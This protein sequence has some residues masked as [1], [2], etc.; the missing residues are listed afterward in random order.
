MEEKRFYISTPIYYP[1]AKAHIGHA[2]T[3]VLS[4]AMVRYKKM[5]GYETFFLTGMDEHGQKVARAAKEAGKTPQA[6]VDEM[7][8]MWSGLWKSLLIENDDFIRT[9]EK[10]HIDAV[11][12]IFR[13]I[14]DKGDI[15]LSEYEGWYC[16]P[17]ETFFTER[18]LAEGKLCPDCGRP[19]ELVKEEAYFFKMSKYQDQLL[20]HMEQHPDFIQPSSRRNEMINFVKSGLEDLSISRTTF[21]WGIPVP[22]NSK[23]VIYVWFDALSNYLTA[24]GWGTAEDGNY[25]KFWPCDIHLVGKDIVRFHTVIWPAMLL[26]ADIPLP[27]QIFGHGWVLLDSGKMSKSKG[28]VVDPVVLIEKY[29]PEA[30]RYFLL[31]EIPSGADGYYAEI[32]LAQRV[33]T[34]LANDFGNLVSR[35]V[36]MAEK[37]FDGKAPAPGPEEEPDRELRELASEV[38]GEAA[39]FMDKMDFSGALAAIFRLIGRANKYID[40]TMPWQLAK[41]PDKQVRLGT[42]IYYLLEVVRESALLLSPATPLVPGKVWAQIGVQ[43]E[44]NKSWDD[45]KWGGVEPGAQVRKGANLFPRIELSSLEGEPDHGH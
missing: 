36:A 1:S 38:A 21:D 15:Y 7:A 22:I 45:L 28:N 42:V 37:Y 44:R 27:K 17:C 41:D 31:R 43:P 39:G 11:Q 10:R 2:L 40:E 5:R 3:T 6:H 12:E 30:I 24:L 26:S 20:E 13:R 23:H 33:N 29:G 25:Q 32:S 14:Y 35:S 34:D 9:T 4:D 19:V 18:Q 16:T 8:E